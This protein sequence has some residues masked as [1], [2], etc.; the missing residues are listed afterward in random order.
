M[1][2]SE[3]SALDADDQ[4]L[5]LLG[6]IA[7][8]AIRME[9]Q[10]RG[11]HA[12]L[13]HDEVTRAALFDTP[14][15][16]GDLQ[17]EARKKVNQ[18]EIEGDTRAAILSALEAAHTAY[19]GRN[20]YMHRELLRHE[21]WD[22]EQPPPEVPPVLIPDSRLRVELSSDSGI[23][24]PEPVTLE[25]AHSL[26]RD[27]IGAGWRLRFARLHL[28]ARESWKSELMAH[29]EGTW[30]GNADLMGGDDDD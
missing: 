13:H 16:W 10:L 23:P 17:K 7:T 22:T 6:R 18:L 20:K 29:V 9:T 1:E 3:L 25:E 11:L 30:D 15:R 26:V 4:W 12:W 28:M 5:L 2:L 14:R 27:L 8:E 21:Q 24:A 19:D